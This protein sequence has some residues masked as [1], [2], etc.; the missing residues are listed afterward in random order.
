[1]KFIAFK[2]LYLLV[3]I[4]LMKIVNWCGSPRFKEFIVHGIAFVAFHVSRNKRRLSEE[5]L[6][7]AFGGRLT[8]NRRREIIKRAFYEFW[9]DAFSLLPSRAERAVLKRARLRGVEH[10]SQALE[11][12]KGVILWA[13]NHFGKMV[14]AKQILHEYGFPVH[15]VHVENHLG[16]FRNNGDPETWVQHRF[17][18]PFFERCEEAF[19]AGIVYLPSSDSLAFTRVFLDRLKQN[20][21]VCVAGDA[22]HGRKLIPL[23]FLGFTEVFPTGIVTLAKISGAPI[24][25]MLCIQEQNGETCAIVERPIHIETT[26][27][28]DRAAADSIAQYLTVLEAYTRRYPEQYRNWHMLGEM[29]PQ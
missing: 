10:L 9:S 4:G 28:R 3:V 15:K 22:K 16:G 11:G 6:G 18:G 8:E 21:I 25:P 20:A 12:G 27:D 14:L 26:V 5:N 13:S 29:T 19:V 17:I 2:D 1:M 24:L 23:E 7:R